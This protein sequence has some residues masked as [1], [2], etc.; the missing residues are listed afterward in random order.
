[1]I[2]RLLKY[3]IKK[4]TKILV[5]MY[6][7]SIA[8]A[9]ITRFINIWKDIPAINI[10]GLVFAG[11]TYS[12]IGNVLVNTFVHILSVFIK[13]FYKD[14][15]YLTHTLP[16][17]KSDLL[18]SKYISAVIVVFLGVAVSFLSLFIL[19]YSKSFMTVIGN[20]ISATVADFN[21]SSGAFI[22][23][24]SVLIFLELCSFITMGFAA[25]IKANT[26]NTKR[27]L[28]SFV[29]FIIFYFIT[30]A[31]TVLSAIAL[32]AISGSVSELLSTTLSASAFIR[33]IWLAI[34]D[35]F[36]YSVVFFFISHKLFARG[37]NV[38]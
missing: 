34:I 31:A 9:G 3:D 10:L 15:S 29:W 21:M 18:N 36:V 26:Y 32:F 33:L 30:M 11:C 16:V 20:F 5:Y 25:I 38:D 24:I 37:V 2:A 8:L 12:A 13:S 28:R 23:L 6:V 17:K 1:M 22:S 14:E 19:F 4:M 27:T 35:Y 7:I